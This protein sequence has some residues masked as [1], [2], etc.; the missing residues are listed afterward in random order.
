MPIKF[1]SHSWYVL[2]ILRWRPRLKY[3]IIRWI[4][5]LVTFSSSWL[6]L[7][8]AIGVSVRQRWRRR[9]QLFNRFV[10]IRIARCYVLFLFSS[11]KCVNCAPATLF[12]LYLT[13]L[14]H[15]RF[16]FSFKLFATRMCVCT[17]KKPSVFVY[18]F[19]WLLELCMRKCVYHI[20][21]WFFHSKWKK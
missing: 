17:P 19:C 7:F 16:F 21:I 20:S 14:T 8:H 9:R 1:D 5:F 6:S 18:C 13:C 12:T 3:C 15:F 11:T 4:F 10:C 2:W